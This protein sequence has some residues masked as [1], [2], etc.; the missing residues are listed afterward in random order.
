MT[1]WDAAALLFYYSVTSTI[2]RDAVF[3]VKRLMWRFSILNQWFMIIT[4]LQQHLLVKNVVLQMQSDNNL[5]CWSSRGGF[6]RLREW[7]SLI[8]D[9]SYNY[10]Y[11]LARCKKKYGKHETTP[12]SSQHFPFNVK[13]LFSL[14]LPL[15]V[16]FDPH[17]RF[18][19]QLWLWP[20]VLPPPVKAFGTLS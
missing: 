11:L 10:S 4:F 3:L 5:L 8:L 15:S 13:Y 9:N 14:C 20:S 7:M 6:S 18:V 19:Q 16:L 12:P 1:E 2:A 17:S